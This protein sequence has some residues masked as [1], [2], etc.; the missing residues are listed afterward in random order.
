MGIAWFGII[1]KKKIKKKPK[2]PNKTEH[3]CL[4][5]AGSVGMETA[6]G[7]TVLFIIRLEEEQT[8]HSGQNGE[9]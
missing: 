9:Q 6:S 1:K 4:E 5:R 3:Y 2:Q 7:L 8:W